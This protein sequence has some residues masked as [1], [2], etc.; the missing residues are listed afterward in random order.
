MVTNFFQCIGRVKIA[1]FLSLSRQ[2]II[3]LPLILI[4]PLIWGL[5][6]L[7]ASL[8]TS[9]GLAALIAAVVMAVYLRKFKTYGAEETNH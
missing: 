9:D 8:P 5:D 4:L 7:W 6:G 1:I 2:L 3:L